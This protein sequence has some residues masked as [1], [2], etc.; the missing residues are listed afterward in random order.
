MIII[1]ITFIIIKLGGS[2]G[3]GAIILLG[4]HEDVDL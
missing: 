1:I 4:E 2:K 3:K